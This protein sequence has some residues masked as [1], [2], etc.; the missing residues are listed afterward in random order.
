VILVSLLGVVVDEFLDADLDKLDLGEDLVGG[1]SP[2]ERLRVGVPGGDLVTD[3][4]EQHIDRGEGAATDRLTGDDRKSG[5]DL[6]DPRRS[7][8]S[9][10]ELHVLVC[11]QPGHDVRRGVR[12]QVVQH[13]MVCLPACGATARC[14]NAR[15]SSPLRVGLHSPDTSPVPTFNAANRFVVPCRT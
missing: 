4:G 11:L 15:K 7:D 1:G 12:G 5:V 8:G 6:I 2:S 9:E 14:R 13:H 10:V 3:L